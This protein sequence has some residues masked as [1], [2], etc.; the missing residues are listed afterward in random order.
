MVTLFSKDM[1]TLDYSWM[2]ERVQRCYE[3]I[4]DVAGQILAIGGNV[5]LDLGFT[6][7]T[8]RALFV[9]W[10]SELDAISEVHFLDAPKEVRQQRVEQ[11]NR[12]KD[13]SVYA[14]D[15]TDM[16]FNFMESRF[17]APDEKELRNGCSV[18]T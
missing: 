17:E 10:A 9:D 5:V 12:D 2:I 8:Q 16:M 18:E 11:R 13:P 6:E 7:K 14:F 3:Q 4:W 15:V 1:T